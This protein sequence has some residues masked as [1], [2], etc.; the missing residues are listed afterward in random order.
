MD[1]LRNQSHSLIADNHGPPENVFDIQE[2]LKA[3]VT[4]ASPFKS[5]DVLLFEH[6]R[7]RFY[8]F[9][10]LSCAAQGVFWTS[11]AAAALA[12]PHSPA[13]SPP[14]GMEAEAEVAPARRRPARG[15]ALWRHGLAL[16][17]AAIG[18]LV[19]TAGLLFSHRSV[20]SVL[21]QAGRQ[22]VTVTTHGPFSLGAE[23][24]VPLRHV[25]CLAH[26]GEVSA[27]LPLKVKG[28]CFCFLLDKAGRFP[29]LRLFEVTVE[30]YQSL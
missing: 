2:P 21:L 7:G 24:T 5:Q 13:W 15:S 19:L 27:V 3:E 26:R 6:E 28:R 20:H 1:K 17:C 16:A 25:S 18:S 30:A 11:L 12:W 10:G 9:L 29:N 4:L 23:F 22:R 14:S 8:G